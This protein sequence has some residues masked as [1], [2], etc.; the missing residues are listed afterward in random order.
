MLQN[1]IKSVGKKFKKKELNFH[2]FKKLL[3]RSDRDSTIL[4]EN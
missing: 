3:S 1:G 4:K 2:S